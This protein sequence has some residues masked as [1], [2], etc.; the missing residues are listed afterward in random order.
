MSLLLPVASNARALASEIDA[1]IVNGI[2]RDLDTSPAVAREV[3]RIMLC[4]RIADVPA[5]VELAGSAH[6]TPVGDPGAP[7]PD[8]VVP[9][10]DAVE[11]D[12]DDTADDEGDAEASPEWRALEDGLVNT[13]RYAFLADSV[14]AAMEAG[15]LEKAGEPFRKHKLSREIRTY[16]RLTSTG[17]ALADKYIARQAAQYASRP[18]LA[19]R[20]TFHEQ[21]KAA[22]KSGYLK[23]R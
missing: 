11:D 10:L 16:V 19:A 23:P 4:E 5:C 17:R 18:S 1:S 13:K 20:G 21:V 3:H 22:V 9:V 7:D 15:V 14:N 12:E 8:E 6:H 2:A